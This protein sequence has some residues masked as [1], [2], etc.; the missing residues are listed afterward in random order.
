MMT[1]VVWEDWRFERQVTIVSLLQLGTFPGGLGSER[2]V[3]GRGEGR[4]GTSAT[5]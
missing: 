5:K 4:W 1:S 3:K 2:E